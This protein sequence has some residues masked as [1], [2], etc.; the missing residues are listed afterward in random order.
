[1]E[2]HFQLLPID[3]D[4]GHIRWSQSVIKKHFRVQ[5]GAVSVKISFWGHFCGPMVPKFL[6][7]FTKFAPVVV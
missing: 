7:F 3:K 4:R 5:I 6:Y 2:G 1:M